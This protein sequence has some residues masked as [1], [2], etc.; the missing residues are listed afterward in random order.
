MKTMT[1][2]MTGTIL[3]LLA[4][5]SFV[6]CK[7]RISQGPCATCP[8]P[9]GSTATSTFTGTL[10]PTVLPTGSATS[11]QTSTQTPT[12]T[13]MITTTWTDTP[14]PLATNTL[15]PLQPTSTPTNGSATATWTG[16]ATSSPTKTSTS[17]VTSTPT[18]ASPTSTWTT[19]VTATFTPT[20]SATPT[21]GISCGFS[22]LGNTTTNG[23]SLPSAAAGTFYQQ[24]VAAGSG[25][26][27]Q[28]WVDTHGPR[29]IEFGI[30]SDLA[31]QPNNQIFLSGPVTFSCAWWQSTFLS[32]P[33]L[34]AGATYWV[35]MYGPDNEF[36]VNNPGTGYSFQSGL[37]A[38]VYVPGGAT[39]YTGSLGVWVGACSAGPTPTCAFSFPTAAPTPPPPDHLID[40]FE[41]GDTSMNP[42]LL[43][44]GGLGTWTLESWAGNTVNSPFIFTNWAG[45]LGTAGYMH[46]FGPIH[47]AADGTYPAFLLKGFL[48]GGTSY[49]A[50]SYTGI[51]FYYNVSTSDTCPH[52]RFNIATAWT[53]PVAEGGN[54]TCTS[55]Y[56]HYGANFAAGSTGG[57]VLK[58]YAFTSLQRQGFEVPSLP[59]SMPTSMTTDF[60]RLEIEF[61][62]NGTFGDSTVDYATDEWSFF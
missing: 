19:V 41:D 56:D 60:N 35:A 12:P 32:G 15:T 42:Y 6:G 40:N 26:I 34:T 62:R 45:A 49:D 7:S 36:G 44:S 31:G 20:G 61:G 33:T 29:V 39:T 51:Q 52:R 21:P 17:L 48:H 55:C 16:T 23:Y 27:N 13:R 1:G 47:D 59:M 18:P 53:L 14:T 5:C 3:L 8:D 30:Y 28:L 24:F 50:S 54:G 9:A 11:T 22:L 57:W 43:N 2:H 58:S 46:A 38:P 4:V 10:S 37:P 25:T